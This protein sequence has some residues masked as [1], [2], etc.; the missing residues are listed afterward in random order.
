[1]YQFHASIHAMPNQAVASSNML[2]IGS[3]QVKPLQIDP[4]ATGQPMTVSFE[5]TE[6][7]LNNFPNL[8]IEPDG[9]FV[10][11]ASA[12]DSVSWQIDGMLY[13]RDDRML[14]AEIKGSCPETEFDRLL[15]TLG[16]PKSTL[17]FQSTQHAAYFTEA[18]F[19]AISL[20]G[21][22]EFRHSD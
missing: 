5:Q 9:S 22:K 15:K 21:E 18:D 2:Q 8:F 13:D 19:R 20:V 12:E 6:E 17:M 4:H 3:H 11:V 1:M 7:A 16:W 14:F 10:W